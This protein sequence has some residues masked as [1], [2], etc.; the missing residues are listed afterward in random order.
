MK[1]RHLIDRGCIFVGHGL[2]QD[3]RVI[4]ILVPPEN[5]LDTVEL[6]YLGH[7]KLSL[8]FL[9][10]YLLEEDIQGRTHD[11]IEDAR[12]AL[13]LYEKFKEFESAGILQDKLTEIFEEG[14]K[15]NFR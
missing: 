3:F 8:R 7:R 13:K 14:R 2:T 11:S 5:I 4:N 1:L 6:F 9:A 10:S 15:R 12:T